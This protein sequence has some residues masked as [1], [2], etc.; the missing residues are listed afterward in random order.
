M[1]EIIKL[2]RD[3]TS[4]SLN[5]LRWCLLFVLFSAALVGNYHYPQ[6]VNSLR[7]LAWILFS[8]VLFGIFL[9]TTQG[10]RFYKFAKAARNEMRK[11][12]W[13]TRQET[14][15]STIAVVAL[16]SILALVLW[17]FDSLWLWLVTLITG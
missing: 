11:V 8:I 5:V 14:M 13:P 6:L 10:A 17:M 1:A 12:V 2:K 9:S 7:L 4:K 3:E 15:Q 16:V